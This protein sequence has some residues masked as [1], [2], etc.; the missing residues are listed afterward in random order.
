MKQLIGI[1]VILLLL[2][3]CSDEDTV[4]PPEPCNTSFSVDSLQIEVRHIYLKLLDI[5]LWTVHAS[6]W[7]EIND[8]RAWI[9]LHEF[10]FS[11][12][13]DTLYYFDNIIPEICEP[14]NGRFYKGG[15]TSTEDDLFSVRFPAGISIIT[16]RDEEILE[17]EAIGC[18]ECDVPLSPFRL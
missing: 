1:F 7:Y 3:S 15:G 4:A 18:Y 9:Y 12:T 13:S 11:E 2:A 6:Y 8:Y 14:T 10:I 16:R 5:W 17:P